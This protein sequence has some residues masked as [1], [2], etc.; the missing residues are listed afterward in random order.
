M[1]L[2]KRKLNPIRRRLQSTAEVHRLLFHSHLAI[3]LVWVHIYIK[4]PFAGKL[5]IMEEK[6]AKSLGRHLDTNELLRNGDEKDV[7][8]SNG[9]FSVVFDG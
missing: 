2:Q 6:Q 9:L 7:E 5:A 1:E 8:A 3:C 4:F